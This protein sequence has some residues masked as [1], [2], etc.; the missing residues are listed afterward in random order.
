MIPG[1]EVRYNINGS[2]YISVTQLL[3][4][5][6]K[7]GEGLAKWEKKMG[8]PT[9]AAVVRGRRALIGSVIHYR[10]ERWLCRYFREPM[11]MRVK[12]K[13]DDGRQAVLS[14]FNQEMRDAIASIWSYFEE[15]VVP[16][17]ESGDLVPLYI[18]KKLWHEDYLYA[19]TVDLICKYK[20]ELVIMDWKT[21]NWLVDD[22]S[23][24]AQLTAYELAAIKRG[25]I[26][27]QADALYVVR[28]NE[29]HDGVDVHRC[30]RDW[31]KFERCLNRYYELA[32]IQ[33]IRPQ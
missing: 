27:R 3:D 16:L 33:P 13:W 24:G 19:G 29:K 8:G 31:P 11:P 9:K 1:L 26:P 30:A 5:D 21:A 23:Y 25:V 7:K 2:P 18:E 10:I 15:W 14:D 4:L 17:A 32:G 6:P 12:L 22:H 28:I 20:G